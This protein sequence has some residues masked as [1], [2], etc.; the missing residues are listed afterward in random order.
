ML[1]WLFVVFLIYLHIVRG[2]KTAE[3]KELANNL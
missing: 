1:N 2:A 3:M